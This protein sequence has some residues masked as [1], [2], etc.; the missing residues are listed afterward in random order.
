MIAFS[1]SKIL[2]GA[3]VPI[4]LILQEDDYMSFGGGLIQIG[5]GPVALEI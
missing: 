2:N 5:K 1:V 3:R 4:G